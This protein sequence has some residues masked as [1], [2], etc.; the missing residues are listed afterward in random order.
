VL[1]SKNEKTLVQYP[2]GKTATSFTIPNDVTDIGYIAFFGCY[3]LSSITI[4]ASV[5]NIGDYAFYNCSNLTS[6]ICE[7]E[8]P[9]VCGSGVFDYVDKSIPLYI[10]TNSIEAYS[11][12]DEWKKFTN[13][14]PLSAL[15]TTIE[16]IRQQ[17]TSTAEQV[18]KVMRD[19]V[20]YILMPNSRMYDIRGAEIK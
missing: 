20:M 8:N 13:R 18:H 12:A 11:E 5:T 1:F 17:D 9:P 7:A 2:V 6:I 3:S 4:P 19:G 10:P 15:P 14:K 16:D